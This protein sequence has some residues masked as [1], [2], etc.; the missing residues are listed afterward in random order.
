MFFH[1]SGRQAYQC[2][3]SASFWWRAK[4]QNTYFPVEAIFDAQACGGCRL[5]K[6]TGEWMAR[7]PFAQLK[8]PAVY[9]CHA[10]RD[11]FAEV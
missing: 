11:F 9:T 10:H 5:G 2:A 4:F 3:T 6:D 8:N 1:L 7:E